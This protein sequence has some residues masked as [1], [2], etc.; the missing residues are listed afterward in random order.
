M[1][2]TDPTMTV[3]AKPAKLS[4]MARRGR[5]SNPDY[6]PRYPNRIKNV[7]Q[8]RGLTQQQLGAMVHHESTTISK[9]EMGKLQLKL[10]QLLRFANALHV[11]IRALLPFDPANGVSVVGKINRDGVIVSPH[12]REGVTVECPA[13]LDPRTTLAAEVA[14]NALYPLHN[15][16]F[17]FFD[18]AD[19]QIDPEA[20][21]KLCVVQ[22]MHGAP[23]MV[24]Q[25]RA[26]RDGRFSLW[27]ARGPLV[28]D[29]SIESA[30]QI[31]MVVDRQL[32]H[33]VGPAEVVDLPDDMPALLE[34]TD[35]PSP[36]RRIERSH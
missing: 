15:G 14:E 16:N 26:A 7:R 21:G 3:G 10:P 36:F 23:L 4:V 29:V 18:R 25:L 5:P 11:D 28:E 31:R 17:V 9:L 32:V 12:A 2:L 19:R 6:I 27:S 22:R 35:D 30:G 34:A 33:Q 1:F 24:G 13:G 8:L 20:D